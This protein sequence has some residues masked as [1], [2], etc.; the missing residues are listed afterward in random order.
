MAEAPIRRK[1]LRVGMIQDGRIVD[2]QI[3]APGRTVFVGSDRRCTLVVRG[4]GLPPRVPLL[5]CRNG[6]YELILH[7][8][9]RARLVSSHGAVE[10][11]GGPSSSSIQI[12]KDMRGKVVIEG[13]TI[14]FQF[15]PVYPRLSVPLSGVGIRAWLR[16]RDP[17][18]AVVLALSVLLH[19]TVMGYAWTRPPPPRPTWEEV[20]DRFPA[21]LLPYRNLQTTPTPP[22]ER[23]DPKAQ[24]TSRKPESDAEHPRSSAPRQEDPDR[25]APGA[26]D[27]VLRVG[28]LGALTD[29]RHRGGHIPA[30]QADAAP[31][32]GDADLLALLDRGAEGMEAGT[33]A[34]FGRLRGPARGEHLVGTTEVAPVASHVVVSTERREAR[35]VPTARLETTGELAGKLEG[36]DIGAVIARR[37]PAITACYE[38]ALKTHPDLSGKVYLTF[39]IEENGRISRVEVTGPA[40]ADERL[41]GCIVR[42]V[43]RWKFPRIAEGGAEVTL[44]IVLASGG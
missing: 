5:V 6:R 29:L 34:G 44:P 18:F 19:S 37:M 43:R 12:E 25:R 21:R 7:E 39:Q 36:S 27:R 2:E 16:R 23:N 11:R 35:A 10:D 31:V 28:I 15:V 3:V 4:L 14:L 38:M 40:A 22:P 9:W 42:R 17:V 33:V 20:V 32:P 13:T 8:G 24:S 30:L 1:A 41:T 26:H